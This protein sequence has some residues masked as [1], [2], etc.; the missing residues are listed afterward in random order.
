MDWECEVEDIEIC[1][2][3]VYKSE[4]PHYFE[5]VSSREPALSSYV[6]WWSK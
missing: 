6:N 5:F 1:S 3:C 2:E 4:C